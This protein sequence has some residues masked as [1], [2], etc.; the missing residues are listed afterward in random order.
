[1]RTIQC[2]LISALLCA[3]VGAC[4]SG[5]SPVEPGNNP[6]QLAY[7]DA[8]A[9]PSSSA[10]VTWG[11]WDVFIDPDDLTADLVPIRGANFKCNVV[12]F[13]Q[14]PKAPTNLI[15]V[16][17]DPYGTNLPAG[18]VNC[19]ITL[20]HPFPGSVFCG[21]DVQ[22]IVIGEHPNYAWESDPTIISS[23]PPFTILQNPDGWTRW[24]N[25]PEFTTYGKLFGYIEGNLAHH[26]WTSTHTLNAYKVFA[27]DIESDTPFSPYQEY[28]CFFSSSEPGSN[29]RR[30]QLQFPGA[31]GVMF[32]F[33]Y[34]VSAC[35]AEPLPG[36]TSP[37]S[38]DDFPITANQPEPFQVDFINTGSSAYYEDES[39]YG[40]NI[41]G[42][43][44]IRD[45]QFTGSLSTVKDEIA[46]VKI[47]SPTLFD[48]VI[49][50]DLDT[51]TLDPDDSLTILIPFTIEDVSPSDAHNQLLLV[52]VLSANPTTYEP[53]IPGITGFDYPDA[54]LAA[55]GVIKMAIISS[56]VGWARTWGGMYSDAGSAVCPD[57]SGNVYVTGYFSDTVDLDPGPSEDS[58]TSHAFKDAYI[59]KFSPSGTFLWGRSWGGA[60][61]DGGSDVIADIAGNIYVTGYF[62]GTVDFDPGA[63][64]DW[65]TFDGFYDVFLSK[66][67]SSGEFLWARTWGGVDPDCGF[68][69]C[70]DQD[71]DII[72]S[73]QFCQDVDFDPGPDTDWHTSA[74]N[75]DVFISRFDSSGNFIWARTWGGN[76]HDVSYCVT[77][78]TYG[79]VHVTGSFA[80]AADFDP[81]PGE[82]LHQSIGVCDCFLSEFD[83]TG[84]FL[85]A[86]T[87]GGDQAESGFGVAA[88]SLGN[89]Y[90]IGSFCGTTDFDPG[91]DEDYHVSNG[92]EDVFLSK[93]DLSGSFMGVRT[94][95]GNYDD[96]GTS[97][98][99]DCFGNLYTA[100]WFC[101]I[102]DFDPGPGADQR[103]S[104]STDDAFVSKFGYS[105]DYVWARTWGGSQY[106]RAIDLVVDQVGNIYVTGWF[107]GTSDFD[108]SNGEDWHESKG[109]E[110]AFL[111]KLRPD[112]YL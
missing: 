55:Y 77:A 88:D 58:H 12:N 86:T 35:W 60:W 78:D 89:T 69:I 82:E 105:G 98:S 29:T 102:V 26:G 11:M 62:A 95:G 48:G 51:A 30:Y 90:V 56:K 3:L 63:G 20:E 111:I 15:D 100:G 75:Y 36:S 43:I 44:K 92:G 23:L 53:Q 104:I 50:L 46:G 40:G 52:T 42:S 110:E 19:L 106:D 57:S 25:Q 7:G 93:F 31:G 34:A 24:W 83:S 49:S 79:D 21:F 16:Q 47:E 22:G 94:W 8:T 17:I 45:W 73:G 80:G 10:R 9:M 59:S 14:P 70:M 6:A 107:C 2:I 109:I 74:G 97:V 81:G 108:P 85:L 67:D 5:H 13:L 18:K 54:P 112:G 33:K 1:M 76:G 28:R 103:V 38:P 61:E 96:R 72:V 71:E 101:G 4:S 84:N 66:F 68:G 32:H 64:E 27:D 65:H 37:Y 39:D 99:T 91:L 41:V 87:W